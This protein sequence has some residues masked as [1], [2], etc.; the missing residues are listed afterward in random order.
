MTET[1]PEAKQ[2]LIFETA[3]RGEYG[4]KLCERHYF[5]HV[6]GCGE[7]IIQ[8]AGQLAEV[9][10]EIDEEFDNLDNL[11]DELK[12]SIESTQQGGEE[13]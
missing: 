10:Q 13:Q 7:C 2:R 8:T 1:G 6:E 4:L 9:M 12:E 5:A 3:V 11:L